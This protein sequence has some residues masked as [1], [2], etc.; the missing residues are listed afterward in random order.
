M[1][2]PGRRSQVI[3]NETHNATHATVE[4]NIL[5]SDLS[6]DLQHRQILDSTTS[7]LLAQSSVLQACLTEAAA[8]TTTSPVL[9]ESDS[10][11]SVGDIDGSK[12]IQ[13][14]PVLY[15]RHPN[16]VEVTGGQHKCQPA[17]PLRHSYQ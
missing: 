1:S 17:P 9:E 16:R 6:D 12:I 14:S 13:H 5:R 4:A 3:T 15:R 10:Q 11:E 2:N 7:L 8:V